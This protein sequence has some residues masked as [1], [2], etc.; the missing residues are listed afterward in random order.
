MSIIPGLNLPTITSLTQTPWPQLKGACAAFGLSGTARYSYW[1]FPA[2]AGTVF[3][4]YDHFVNSWL[5]LASPAVYI[6][7]D[8]G[9]AAMAFDETNGQVY[10]YAGKADGFAAILTRY[11]VSTN[12]WTAQTVSV[13][14]MLKHTTAVALCWPSSATYPGG[15][16]GKL[17]I[18]GNISQVISTYEPATATWV[19]HLSRGA[20]V[21]A[22][23]GLLWAPGFAAGKIISP[24]GG[25]AAVDFY[26]I[27]GNS[28][29]SQNLTPATDAPTTGWA[30]SNVATIPNVI[31]AR[32]LFSRAARVQLQA[33]G[34][35]VVSG[36]AAFGLTDGTAVQHSCFGA[37]AIEGPDGFVHQLL[38]AQAAAVQAF[39]RAE[40]IA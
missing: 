8:L 5:L 18:V 2:V 37:M 35:L 28:W 19:D 27:A 23:C 29:T 31:F 16:A 12:A 39:S 30:W 1:L 9:T 40:L 11:N 4:R 10:L 3:Y 7:T 15:S 26:D 24:R 34:D 36:A 21:A 17:Y 33:S 22:G 14:V 13:G 32:T 6:S 20:A 25:S 38:Y